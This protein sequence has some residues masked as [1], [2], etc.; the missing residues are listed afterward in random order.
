MKISIILIDGSFRENVFGAKYFTRQNFPVDQYEVLWVEFYEKANPEVYE[1]QQQGLKIICLGNSRATTYHSSFCFNEGI[2]NAKGEIVVIP[3]ADQIVEENFL[4][5]V[6]EAHQ[7]HEKLLIYGYRY[8]EITPRSIQSDD[9]AEVKSKCRMKN[10]TNYGGCL[11][12]RKKWLEAIN[13]YEEHWFFE[14]GFHANGSDI[15]HRLKNFGLFTKWDTHLR[16][17]H[18][19]HENS[20]VPLKELEQYNLQFE[21]INWRARNFIILPFNG[22]SSELN[23]KDEFPFSPQQIEE[24]KQ[25]KAPPITESIGKR[26]ARKITSLFK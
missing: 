21:L 12:V 8:D 3:D 14:T 15:Y 7:E 23:F 16:L 22:L 25:R 20:Q 4:S 18:P 1:Y 11:T 10:I 24:I 2:K 26:I 19:W 9:I 13:G 5:K 6:W 17:Y